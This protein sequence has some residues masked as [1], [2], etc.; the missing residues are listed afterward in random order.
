MKACLG[1]RTWPRRWVRS[2]CSRRGRL[3][4]SVHD[5]GRP[6]LQLVQGRRATRFQINDNLAWTEGP[7]Q[8]KFGIGSR[9][10]RIDDYD[11]S[12]Y[13]TPL[14]EYTTLAQFIY[15]VASTAT[16]AFPVAASQPFN[17]LTWTC[18]RRTP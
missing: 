3:E 5:A 11:F 15:G 4:R 8:F 14:V 1:R 17:Y 2:D 16:K 7:H 6:R 10:L 18:S 9:R 13:V 12:N